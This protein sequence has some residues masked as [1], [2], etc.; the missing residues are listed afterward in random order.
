MEVGGLDFSKESLMKTKLWP[1]PIPPVQAAK[2]R[3]VKGSGHYRPSTVAQN[4][5][6]DFCCHRHPPSCFL[7][8]LVS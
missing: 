7:T 5:S 8:N 4:L 3:H 6:E 2:L 1:L